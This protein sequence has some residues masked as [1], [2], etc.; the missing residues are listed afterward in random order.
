MSLATSSSSSSTASFQLVTSPSAIFSQTIPGLSAPNGLASAGLQ[1]V[2]DGVS[3]AYIVNTTHVMWLPFGSPSSSSG[4]DGTPSTT[5]SSGATVTASSTDNGS[6]SDNG[7][8]ASGGFGHATFQ[9]RQAPVLASNIFS[10]NPPLQS[11]GSAVYNAAEKTIV[12]ASVD[13]TK[14]ESISL[15]NKANVLNV[16]PAPGTLNPP[17]QAWLQ[18]NPGGVVYLPGGPSSQTLKSSPWSSITGG[19]STPSSTTAAGP[20]QPNGNHQGASLSSG[21]IAGIV[22]GIVVFVAVVI[23]AVMFLSRRRHRR[24]MTHSQSH[25]QLVER[26]DVKNKEIQGNNGQANYCSLARHDDVETDPATAVTKALLAG[27]VQSGQIHLVDI[28][29]VDVNSFDPMHGIP[30]LASTQGRRSLKKNE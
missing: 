5:S 3:N 11:L 9:R 4:P 18:T 22:V 2:Y 17:V 6:T 30:T 1:L 16:L 13:G 7:P 27:L 8:V 28:H 20:D 23:G 26:E 14:I 15:S 25:H 10:L 29:A 21:A 19:S 24:A 12:V